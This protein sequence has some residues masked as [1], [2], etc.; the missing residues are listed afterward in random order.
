GGVLNVI[1]YIGPWIGATIG[2]ILITTANINL[3]FYSEILPLIL[4]ILAVFA[5]SQLT[6]NIIFQPLI[7]SKSVKAHPLEIFFV[8]IIAGSLYGVLGMMLAIPGYTVIR[9][10]LKEF[11]FQYKFIQQLTQNMN[12]DTVKNKAKDKDD[13]TDL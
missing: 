5:I 6:D 1:P 7:Y 13:K 2:V 12:T 8:I 9:V 11:L 4:K 10:I 3:D